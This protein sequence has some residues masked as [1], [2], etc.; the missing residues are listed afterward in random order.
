M[1]SLIQMNADKSTVLK[2][3][4]S[5]FFELIDDIISIY[6]DN[7][8]MLTARDA[9]QTFKKM[10][11][12]IIIK[13]WYSGVYTKYQKQIDAGDLDF[14]TEKDYA[15]DIASANDKK[16]LDMIDRVRDPIKNMGEQNKNK[17]KKYINNLC[18]L[19]VVYTE[20]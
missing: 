1:N 13:V 3:F 10:N 6:P 5:V 20:L 12:T 15:D 2:A 17:V 11:P 19:S 7:L 18:R 16:V 9:F 14:F 4:N 8:E